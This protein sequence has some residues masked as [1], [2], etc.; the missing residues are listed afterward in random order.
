MLLSGVVTGKTEVFPPIS[1]SCFDEKRPC[2]WFLLLT[3]IL[4]RRAAMPRL[5]GC[6]PDREEHG[7]A[8]L[9]RRHDG[10][11]G[12]SCTVSLPGP[13]AFSS[14]GSQ[15]T[16]PSANGRERERE[17]E[18]SGRQAAP[19]ARPDSGDKAGSTEKKKKSR[20]RLPCRWSL[21]W[22]CRQPGTGKRGTFGL[23]PKCR[24][25][26]YAGESQVN[27]P[28]RFRPA[29][30]CRYVLVAGEVCGGAV[31]HGG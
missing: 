28:E 10:G 19:R 31:I 2:C 29:P 9:P 30:A 3:D 27:G 5:I 18:S 7:G 8:V 22:H 15:Q 24:G 25:S 12:E 21:F 20:L 14:L 1:R 17:R 4:C 6:R 11:H 23:C 16:N 13:W 26:S